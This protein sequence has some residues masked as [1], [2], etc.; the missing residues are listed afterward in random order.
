MMNKALFTSRNQEWE[1]PQR[2][3]DELNEEFNFTIDLAA[4]SE[5]HKVKRYYNLEH[6]SLQQYWSNERAFL[7][8]PYGRQ[9]GR[10]IKKCAETQKYNKQLS[11]PPLAIDSPVIVALLP[12]RTCTRWF[13]EY[14]YNKPNVTVRFLKGRLK[15]ELGGETVGTAPFPS[16]VIIWR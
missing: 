1:T 12:A 4:N 11:I 15:F 3:F 7:N 16:M 14:I 9:M 2:L 5:N 8:P 6:N 13:H 10:W